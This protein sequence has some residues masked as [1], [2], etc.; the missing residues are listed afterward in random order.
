MRK[1]K[2]LL[3][4]SSL[5]LLGI[6]IACQ[7]EISSWKGDS[8]ERKKEIENARLWYD[9]NKPN[10]VVTKVGDENPNK[11][12]MAPN[13]KQVFIRSDEKYNYVEVSA[14]MGKRVIFMT[15]DMRQKLLEKK[16]EFYKQDMRRFVFRTN[17]E[18]KRTEGFVMTIVPTLDFLEKKKNEI[19]RKLTYT[20]RD[21]D[22]SGYIL[23]NELDGSF[24]N[25]WKYE[26]GKITHKVSKPSKNRSID[27]KSSFDCFDTTIY[28][29]IEECTDHYQYVEYGGMEHFQYMHTSCKYY[30]EI[31]GSYVTCTSNIPIP[32]MGGG[33]GGGSGGD[34]GSSGGYDPIYGDFSGLV[35]NNTALEEDEKMFLKE[36]LEAFVNYSQT[37]VYLVQDLLKAGIKIE[38]KIGGIENKDAHAIYQNGTIRFKNI[39]SIQPQYLEE[40]MIHAAQ[41]KLIYKNMSN[42]DSNYEFEAKVFKDLARLANGAAGYKSA[43]IGQS[44]EFDALYDKWY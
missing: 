2:L 33:S 29:R 6:I 10:N 22:F 20:E 42:N 15:P 11:V 4:L 3:F 26:N 13:W 24:A 31:V 41:H 27:T 25:G 7:D 35:S 43:P 30:S 37:Y 23:F 1:T 38:F 36:S 9:E 12:R 44:D 18:T 16:T 32:N 8:P 40:E 39:N 34:S 17:K 28:Y 14:I 19:F 5:L 21:P